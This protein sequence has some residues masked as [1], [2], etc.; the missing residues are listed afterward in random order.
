MGSTKRIGYSKSIIEFS[1]LFKAL[2][3]P[4]RLKILELIVK[5]GQLNCKS[6][7]FL[8]PL[9]QATISKHT[10]IMIECGILGVECMK[11]NSYY[12]INNE[13]IPLINT[14]LFSKNESLHTLD[15]NYS[16]VY[17]KPNMLQSSF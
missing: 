7:T 8:L 12:T 13:I 3:H 14:Y 5:E 11:N 2:G 16:K 1:N 4:A 17:F 15:L 6:L 10:S 9:S